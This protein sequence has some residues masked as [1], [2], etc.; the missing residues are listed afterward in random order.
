MV[1][2]DHGHSEKLFFARLLDPAL[3][4][5]V[6]GRIRSTC[7]KYG[8]TGTPTAAERLHLSLLNFGDYNEADA[9]AVSQVAATIRFPPFGI[10]LDTALSFRRTSARRP[11][12][13]TS[14]HGADQVRAFHRVLHERFTGNDRKPVKIPSFTPHLTLVWDEKMISDH[15]LERPLSWTARDF[16]LIRSYYG[17][18]RYDINGRWPLLPDG[19][20]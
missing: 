18:G 6:T 9:T 4:Q 10:V 17:K 5:T 7:H 11:Y 16:V 12:V 1:S 15:P 13:L 14:E 19:V 2:V 20:D 3:H 8:F